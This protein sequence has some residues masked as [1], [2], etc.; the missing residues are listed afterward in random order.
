MKKKS[1]A[2]I[3]SLLMCLC[4]LASLSACKNKDE[5]SSKEKEKTTVS[6]EADKNSKNEDDSKNTSDE[7]VPSKSPDAAPAASY[8]IYPSTIECINAYMDFINNRYPVYPDKVYDN[9]SVG[10]SM[11]K[12]S[13]FYTNL[14]PDKAVCF[15][16]F[17]ENFCKS[18]DEFF[19]SNVKVTDIEYAIIDC[20]SDD[21]PEL[22]LNIILNSG[23]D[24]INEIMV[25]KLYKD[26]LSLIF[27][28][29]YSYRSYGSLNQYGFYSSGGSAGAS[30]HVEEFEYIDK[31]GN[32]EFLYGI[33]QNFTT[34]SFYIPDKNKH[35][36]VA[37]DLGISDQM[38]IDAYYFVPYDSSMDYSQWQKHKCFHTFSLL[39]EYTSTIDSSSIY[40]DNSDY[41]TFWKETGLDLYTQKEIDKMIS[42]R[43]NVLGVSKNDIQ[44]VDITWMSLS[45]SQYENVLS[46]ANIEPE[47]VTLSTPSWIYYDNTPE[48]TKTN[49]N[50]TQV[51]V[52]PNNITDTAAWASS[53][54]WYIPDR[55]SF[56]DD[57]YYFELSGTDSAG[58]EWYPYIMDIYDRYTD[59][60]LYSIDFSNYYYPDQYVQEDL[61]FVEESI[62]YA[63]ICDNILY[64]STFHNTYAASAPHN[65]Y[66]TAID[67]N[68]NFTVLWRSDPLTCNSNNFIVTDDAIICGYGFTAEDDYIYIL[69]RSDGM[70][71]KSILVKTSPD[72][73]HFVEDELHVR[74]YNV[75]YVF[76]VSR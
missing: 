71:Q 59:D 73:F 49:L 61:D 4:L 51:S 65:G 16:E 11:L 47:K 30:S 66:I 21:I 1:H 34:F 12:S 72:Y 8:S 57:N 36:T 67:L 41:M 37:E 35:N 27:E 75:D 55:L 33:D 31:D 53:V 15:S 48:R 7:N 28:S 45:D 3:I 17:L 62:H 52:T 20:G 42:D 39:D 6:K 74:C 46:W 25:F 76:K 10:T 14:A 56:C 32:L 9:R 44:L 68:N 19:Y 60:H 26:R 22:A 54:N 18:H 29:N 5:K 70:R 24:D 69:N 23:Y 2:K 64:V 50:L 63:T 13:P 58:L 38:E 43:L 40:E